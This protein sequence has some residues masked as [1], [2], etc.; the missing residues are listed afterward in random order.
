MIRRVLNS[1]NIKKTK[2]SRR[3]N[4]KNLNLMFVVIILKLK[5]QKRKLRVLIWIIAIIT[6]LKTRKIKCLINS[7]T[8]ENFISQVLIKNA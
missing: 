1:L 2:L 4:K 8:E 6:F 7:K 5:L 3:K